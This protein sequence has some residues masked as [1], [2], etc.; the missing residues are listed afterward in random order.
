MTQA[1]PPVGAAAL[2]SLVSA[3]AVAELK[4]RVLDAEPC[5]H[6]VID[7]FLHPDVAARAQA[8]ID[9]FS[10]RWNLRRHHGQRKRVFTRHPDMPPTVREIVTLLHGHEFIRHVE[11]ATGT[12]ALLMDPALDGGGLC[13]MRTGDFMRP[14]LDSPAHPAR[15]FWQRRHALFVFLSR[16][17]RTD[18]GGALTLWRPGGEGEP[19]HI[20]PRFNRFVLFADPAGVVHGVSPI[21]C[22]PDAAR[23]S[24]AVYYYTEQSRAIPLRPTM[25]RDP[26]EARRPLLIERVNQTL[27]WVYFAL[28]RRRGSPR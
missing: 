19:L 22:P 3:R 23:R 14:H 28:R 18:Y 5:A 8:E 13:E 12:T 2:L 25:Y 9:R 26:D 20:E 6:L 24:I 15:S 16:D 10:G 11:A 17:W 4:R 1:P 21:D 27:L 7:D